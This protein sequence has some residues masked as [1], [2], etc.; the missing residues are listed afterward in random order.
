[1]TACKSEPD[2]SRSCSYNTVLLLSILHFFF[3]PVAEHRVQIWRLI[4]NW[5]KLRCGQISLIFLNFVSVLGTCIENKHSAVHSETL[6]R[7]EPGEHN[8]TT[9]DGRIHGSLAILFL[10]SNV[11]SPA[12]Y[13][14][15]SLLLHLWCST[16]HKIFITPG[17]DQRGWKVGDDKLTSEEKCMYTCTPS[18]HFVPHGH[19]KRLALWSQ[20][21]SRKAPF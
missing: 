16:R 21:S 17:G 4:L 11:F 3:H 14:H 7:V 15:F 9:S 2:T 18:I 10:V 5:R 6:N 19:R 20:V 12:H 8:Y 13:F 1:M